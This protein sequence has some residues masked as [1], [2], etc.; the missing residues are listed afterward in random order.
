MRFP[1]QTFVLLQ[2]IS[3]KN[4]SLLK[5]IIIK[6]LVFFVFFLAACYLLMTFH[7]AGWSF[8][9]SAS[10]CKPVPLHKR[11]ISSSQPPQTQPSKRLWHVS[12]LLV[13]LQ[14]IPGGVRCSWTWLLWCGYGNF[15]C[16][17][18]AL[19]LPGRCKRCR[20][21]SCLKAGLFSMQWQS[22]CQTST[23]LT[24]PRLFHA[25]SFILL[26]GGILPRYKVC[27]LISLEMQAGNIH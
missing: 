19:P 17:D 18:G 27:L 3:S 9:A 10:D 20:L 11:F 6:T 15:P 16:Q 5:K 25:A 12:T 22:L 23:T 1:D 2:Y 13:S 21:L 14:E 7:V 4:L 26:L 24:P 8:C